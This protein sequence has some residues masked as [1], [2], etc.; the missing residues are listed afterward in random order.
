MWSSLTWVL[1]LASA[2]TA[3]PI[4]A[5]VSTAPTVSVSRKE[6]NN[7]TVLRDAAKAVCLRTLAADRWHPYFGAPQQ[8]SAA[9]HACFAENVAECFRH[10][11]PMLA[12]HFEGGDR[13]IER[14]AEAFDTI[15]DATE[16]MEVHAGVCSVDDKEF[17]PFVRL[18]SHAVPAAHTR[19]GR[20]R[21]QQLEKNRRARTQRAEDADSMY[22]GTEHEAE[23]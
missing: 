10:V 11:Q 17:V 19:R 22:I 16:T 14:A 21:R 9:A 7:R 4:Y 15:V 23:L 1:V 3:T 5:V 20:F 13:F 18:R 6:G 2:V 12:E 8:S